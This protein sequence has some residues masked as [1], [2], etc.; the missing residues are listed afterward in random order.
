MEKKLVSEVT[1]DDIS[2]FKKHHGVV[3]QITVKTASGQEQFIIG[4]PTRNQLDAVAKYSQDGKLNKVR[5]L[6]Q[7]SCV[8]AG[9][10]KALENDINLQN[11]VID[12]I[13]EMLEKL[14]VE[15]KEL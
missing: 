14:E 5:E 9:N 12:K 10:I 15:E 3:K 1:P 2:G 6:L 7:N 8:C 4:R 11:T 13:T